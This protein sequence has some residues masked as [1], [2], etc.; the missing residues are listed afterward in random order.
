MWRNFDKFICTAL[1]RSPDYVLKCLSLLGRSCH[2]LRG[3]SWE[4]FLRN[5]DVLGNIRDVSLKEIPGEVPDQC[6]Q[7][8]AETTSRHLQCGHQAAGERAGTGSL[9]SSHSRHLLRMPWKLPE[10][11]A[12]QAVREFSCKSTTGQCRHCW[13]VKLCWLTPAPLWRK[14]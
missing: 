14:K 2:K 5:R 3:T 11:W 4:I 13:F 8:G 1:I 10:G 12:K 9:P 7:T 6:R